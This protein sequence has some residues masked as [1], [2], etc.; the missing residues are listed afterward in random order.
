MVVR[1][2]ADLEYQAEV[3]EWVN[4]DAINIHAGGVYGDKSSALKRLRKTVEMLSDP[5]RKRL[6]LENDDKSYA[7]RDL[8]KLWLS[9]NITVEVEA[10]A[11]ELAVLRLMKALKQP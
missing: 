6:T 4:A 8:P 3:A 2:V 9:M 1:S 11:K 7:P 10:K 5:V